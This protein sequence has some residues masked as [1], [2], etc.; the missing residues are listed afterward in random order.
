MAVMVAA[1]LWLAGCAQ[2]KN[3]PDLVAKPSGTLLAADGRP[4]FDAELVERID[5]STATIPLMT[6]ALRLLR[7]TA[8]GM[9]F[10]TT[11]QAYDNLIAKSKDVIFVTA[12]SQEEQAAAQAAGIELEVIPIVKDALIFLANTA[13]PVDGL[14]D[15]QVKDIYSGKTSSWS[16]VGGADQDIIA[17]Q[18]PVNSGSQTLFLQ[19]AMAGTTPLDA[20]AERRPSA[21]AGLIDVVSGYDNSE[22]ALG[23]SVF[24]YTQEMNAKDNVKALS[25]DGVDPTRE[26]IADETYPYLTYYY[27]VLRADE[28]A[29]S[30][31]RQLVDW[32][33]SSEGQ[34]LASAA[35][36]V[37]LE[38]DNMV[39]PDSGYGYQGSTPEN[40]T[41]S[42]GTGGPKGLSAPFGPDPCPFADCVV[43]DSDGMYLDVKVPG[44]P[45]AE[46]AAQAWFK[47]LPPAKTPDGSKGDISSSIWRVVSTARA[48]RDLLMVSRSVVVPLGGGPELTRESAAFRL[49]DGHQMAL[50]DFFYDGVNYIDFINRNLLNEGTNQPLAE[51]IQD[52]ECVSGWRTAPFTGLPAE[53][54]DFGFGRFGAP[55]LSFQLREGNPFMFATLSGVSADSFVDLNLP[56][57]LSPYG[58]IWRLE[59]V[60]LGDMQVDHVVRA[61]ECLDPRDEALNQSIDAWVTETGRG[62]LAWATVEVGDDGMTIVVDSNSPEGDSLDQARFNFVTGKRID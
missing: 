29:D 54:T 11:P 36:Y 58:A 33:L 10:N 57:D 12:P 48:S 1:A 41:E 6:A 38:Q 52:S 42:N 13:N 22:Q 40:T 39:P 2:A 18:R 21:M 47:A 9:E 43:T 32:L 19:L 31:A 62:G 45:K 55:H 46:S 26:T 44:F 23:Y 50:S 25:I 30:T 60:H 17:Y 27:A 16:Q 61:F 59:Q 5:G 3:Q 34:Q 28:P 53:F 49:L 35:S 24:Y 56:S 14:T 8:D 15:Q 7:G 4:V 37:P 20:P 51:C